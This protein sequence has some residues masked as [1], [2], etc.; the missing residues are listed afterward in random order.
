[1]RRN[2]YSSPVFTQVSH[3]MR[4]LVFPQYQSVTDRRTD[5]QSDRRTDWPQ[6]IQRLRRA[7]KIRSCRLHPFASKNQLGLCIKR[8]RATSVSSA[9]N[10][11]TVHSSSRL[12]FMPTCCVMN[13]RRRF[14]GGH[15]FHK[16]NAWAPPRGL[17]RAASPRSACY[18]CDTRLM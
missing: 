9:Y 15:N 6:H 5:R 16:Q 8:R 18:I 14:R 4:F 3:R 10:Y 13:H 11:T 1:M 17:L 12:K 2:V 7:V